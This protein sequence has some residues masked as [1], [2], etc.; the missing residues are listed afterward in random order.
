M[1][2]TDEFIEEVRAGNDIVDVI[3][4]YVELRHKG[5]SYMGLCPFHSEKTPSFSVYRARQ[6]YHCFGCGKSGDVF[7]FIMEYDHNTFTEAVETLAR[8]AGISIPETSETKEDRALKSLRDRLLE[9]H[10]EAAKY[11]YYALNSKEGEHALS[12]LRGRGLDDKTIK[13]FGLGFAG[14]G[15][16]GLY[17]YLRSKNFTDAELKESG[18]FSIDEASGR[19]RDKFWNRVM[20]P[21]MDHNRRVIGF[22]GRVMGE[23]QPKY[24]NSP[25]TKIFEKSRNLYGLYAA[26]STRKNYMIICEGYMDVITLHSHGFTNAVASLGTALTSQQA[27]LIHRYVKEAILL[28]DSDGAGIKAARRAIPLLKEA[29]INAKVADLKPYKDPDEFL[30]NLGSEELLKRIDNAENGFMYE[31]RQSGSEYD[32]SDPQ[33]M[34]DFR[35]G[36][37]DKLMELSDEIERTSYLE[38]VSRTYGIDKELLRRQVAKRAMKGQP[39]RREP[40]T[41]RDSVSKEKESAALKNERL[42]LSWMSRDIGII[43]YTRQY[44]SDYD[45]TTEIHKIICRALL[46][47]ADSGTLNPVTILNRFEDA[48]E[49]SAA[50]A[51]LEKEQLPEDGKDKETAVKEVLIAIKIQT[52]ERS[53]KNMNTN[54]P[55]EIQR[56]VEEKKKLEELKTAMVGS[57]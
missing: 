21:I 33:G 29:G 37:V 11:Y 57:N 36:I 22:G 18:I 14:K 26:R 30:K 10:K 2:F 38:T 53:L 25:E 17:R 46:V 44:V 9:I 39:V 31:I 4:G 56:F 6:M 54:D 23:G 48:E 5:T 7:N 3:S 13:E 47:Q 51:V 8:R 20:F 32:L 19:V 16:N 12:Y 50:A 1:R 35:N 49:K 52:Y 45:F 15:G 55:A 34:A 40:E 28:Y 42:L 27:A 24:L 41:I 43:E